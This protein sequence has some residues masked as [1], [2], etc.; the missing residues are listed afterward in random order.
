M[1]G[2]VRCGLPLLPFKEIKVRP[3]FDYPN[4]G[5]DSLLIIERNDRFLASWN[6]MSAYFYCLVYDRLEIDS[7]LILLQFLSKTSSFSSFDFS[8]NLSPL[9]ELVFPTQF[10]SS[11]F[12]FSF[13]LFYFL[14]FIYFITVWRFVYVC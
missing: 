7:P 1:R 9:F 4:P 8:M 14:F 6:I 5:G 2:E 11:L 13:P 3:T 10:F 12:L